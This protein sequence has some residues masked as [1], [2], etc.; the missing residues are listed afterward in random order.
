MIEKIRARQRHAR[1]M[2]V[3]TDLVRDA[4]AGGEVSFAQVACLAFARHRMRIDDGEAADYLAAAR[5]ACGYSTDHRP[6]PAV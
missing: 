5:V 2:K 6:A 1:L 3:A 4:A